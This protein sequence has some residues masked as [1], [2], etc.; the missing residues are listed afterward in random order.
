MNLSVHLKFHVGFAKIPKVLR[1]KSLTRRQL[2][3]HFAL[4]FFFFLSSILSLDRSYSKILCT[5][6]QWIL[7]YNLNYTYYYFV[8]FSM[9][10]FLF[11]FFICLVDFM[12]SLL[13]LKH[14]N[15]VKTKERRM[16]GNEIK[17]RQN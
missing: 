14:E 15:G 16:K 12:H 8:L 6:I 17:S 7:Y 4:F 5:F 9:F 1:R 13:K 3:I 10:F 2:Y 11:L